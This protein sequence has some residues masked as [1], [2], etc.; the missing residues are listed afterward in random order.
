LSIASLSANPSPPASARAHDRAGRIPFLALMP[1]YGGTLAAVRALGARGIPVT[2]AGQG[3]LAPARWSRYATRWLSC[4][5]VSDKERL[6]EWLLAFG[7]QE[8]RHVL[9]AP[10]DDLAFLFSAH[11]P[12][13]EKHFYLY[14][15]S[16]TTMVDVLDKRR[17]LEA[18][19]SVG[20]EGVPTWFPDNEADVARIGRE[21]TFPLLLKVR[22]Q[23]RQVQQN[24]GIVVDDAAGLLPA[25]RHFMANHRY[26][27]GLEPYFGDVSRPMVQQYLPRAAERVYSLTGFV[28]RSG[29]LSATRAAVKVFQRTRPVGLGLCFESAPVDPNLAAGVLRLCRALG[30]FGVFE[31]EFLR[32]GDRAMVIDM[33][34]RFY[35]QMG[36]ETA[37][38]LPLALSVY[39]AAI[40]DTEALRDC[41]ASA[42]QV[43]DGATIYAHR[44]VF[45]TLLAVQRASRSMSNGE[46]VRWRDWYRANRHKAADASA[47]PVDWAPGLVHAAAE[48]LPGLRMLYRRL[49]PP[50]QTR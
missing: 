50:K 26:L 14:Q 49:N 27:P 20:V 13:L 47:D 30:H 6:L 16:I 7:R 22:T 43:T 2:V 10:S 37:R 36:F 9:Y 17:L 21:A 11:L 15:P 33:N 42:E 40:G 8:Q 23:V 31:V 39:H 44:F 46:Y 35:G 34:P 25:Y 3:W 48:L 41:L 1:T 24:K 29:A 18:C 4:P 19:R 12:E 45:Q 32:D 5:A 38:G 28:D